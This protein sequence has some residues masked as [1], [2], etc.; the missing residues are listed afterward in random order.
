MGENTKETEDI[1]CGIDVD[2]QADFDLLKVKLTDKVEIE[3]LEAGFKG[4]LIRI[5]NFT[6]DRDL[7]EITNKFDRSL[8][9]KDSLSLQ[10]YTFDEI[11]V[12]WSLFLFDPATLE[13]SN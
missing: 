12:H 9:I 7:V 6:G 8:F 3:T 13:R 10:G 5:D 2:N 4:K 1:F 11:N